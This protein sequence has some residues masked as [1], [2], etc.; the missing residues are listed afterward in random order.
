MF[1]KNKSFIAIAI[2]GISF[3]LFNAA[4]VLAAD[5]TSQVVSIW[6]WY[7]ARA[8]GLVAYVLLFLLVA[9]GIGIKTSALFKFLS[10]TISWMRH[11]YLGMAFS[12]AVIVH[13]VSLLADSYLKLTL[14]DVLVPF[15]SSFKPIFVSLGI[16]GLYLLIAVMISSIFT[17]GLFPKTWRLLHYLTFPLFIILFIH[18]FFI[19]TDTASILI[20]MMYGLTGGVIAMLGIYRLYFFYKQQ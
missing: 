18:G 1:N 8:S 16:I 14:I 5:S 13:L 7:F 17:I 3:L 15:V 2:L 9:S 10:P 4:G 20:K 6:P 11:R 19:G 12:F